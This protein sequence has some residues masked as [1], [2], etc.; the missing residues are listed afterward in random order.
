M[1]EDLVFTDAS[2][3]NREQMAAALDKNV[4]AA[5]RAGGRN[6]NEISRRL[7]LRVLR[8]VN[9]IKGGCTE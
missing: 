3:A 5:H 8:R 4:R 2:E 6:P 1:T 7:P 9:L